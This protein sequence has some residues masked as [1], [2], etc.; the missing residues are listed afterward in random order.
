[1]DVIDN[2]SLGCFL[3]LVELVFVLIDFGLVGCCLLLGWCDV[4][5]WLCGVW[6]VEDLCD[7]VFG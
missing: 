6:C 2:F 1:M 4:L 7:F 3:E 5:E